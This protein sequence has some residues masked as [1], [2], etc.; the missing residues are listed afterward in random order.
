MQ[1]T[2]VRSEVGWHLKG[3]HEMT[4][5]L[6]RDSLTLVLNLLEELLRNTFCRGSEAHA[7]TTGTAAQKT[8]HKLDPETVQ[9]R[10]QALFPYYPEL[11]CLDRRVEQW[12]HLIEELV[13]AVRT[14]LWEGGLAG[15]EE[16]VVGKV[17]YCARASLAVATRIGIV[18]TSEIRNTQ[19]KARSVPP[20]AIRKA[21]LN[22][23]S[24]GPV[25]KDS[26]FL[27]VE[28]Q[29]LAA[30]CATV[31][32]EHEVPYHDLNLPDEVVEAI[33]KKDKAATMRRLLGRIDAILALKLDPV[34][35]KEIWAV[36]KKFQIDFP[37]EVRAFLKWNDGV[38]RDAPGMSK[39]VKC[40]SL[41][42]IYE[43]FF[44]KFG[45]ARL[46]RW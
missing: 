16:E 23:P 11:T 10:W 19:P 8:K 25:F 39:F 44:Y 6:A 41:A 14:V 31:V 1:G 22:D 33:E 5:P 7:T 3:K 12:G 2:Q 13:A 30:Q 43:A 38:P 35:D 9:Q 27:W 32:V 37:P 15:P 42:E 4:L 29:S 17:V 20:R 21:I 40:A 28:P 34:T 26:H 46:M 24:L 45:F 18:A 36:E